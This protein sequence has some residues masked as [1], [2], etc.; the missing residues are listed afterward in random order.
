MRFLLAGSLWTLL[1]PT[2]IYG[3]LTITELRTENL[4]DPIGLDVIKPR[5]SWQLE[6]DRRGVMQVA[7]QLEVRLDGES[8]WNSGKILS[9]QSVFVPYDGPELTSNTTYHWKV[10]IWDQDEKESGWS[11]EAIFQMGIL[12]E[13]VW[14]AR[15]IE[16]TVPEPASRPAQMFRKDFVTEK[17]VTRASLYISSHGVY[18]AYLN[19]A[20][21]GDAYLTPGWTSYNKRIQ[22][23]VYDVTSMVGRGN[24]T[25]GA[26]VGNGWFRGNLAWGGHHNI[27]GKTL[28]LFAQLMITYTDGSTEIIATDA[29]WKSDFSAIRYTEIYHGETIDARKYQ[30]GWN[31]PG[32]DDSSWHPVKVTRDP[33]D[34]LIAT[35]NEPVRKQETFS[36][37]KL[38]TSPKGEKILDFGQNLVGWV[39]V[40]AAGAP[41]DR[42]VLSH[43]EVL[44][45]EGNFYTLS[46]RA[47]KQQNTYILSGTGE[48]TFE[49]HFTW[50]GFRYVRIDE[51]PGEIN[52]L[53][54][55]AVALYSDMPHTGEFTTSNELINQL[56][57]NIQWGQRGN[58]LDVPTDCPQRDERLGWTGD[59]QAF[60]RTAT[61]NFD[62]HNFFAKW[63]K[64]VAAD[65]AADGKVPFVVPDVL[66]PT[67][68]G[69][70][71][72]ADVA[73]IVPWNMYLVYGDKKILSDQYRSMKD[74]IRYMLNNS[75]DFLW[76]KGFHFGDWLFYRPFDDNDGRSA[77]TDKY[78]I[79]QCFFAHSTQ[80][81]INAAKV[82]GQEKDIELY[83]ALLKNV[84]DAF[85]KEYVTPNG[86]LVS[87]TQTAYVLALNFDM[88]PE[89]LRQQAAERLAANVRSYDT[90]LT[91]GFLGTPYLCHVLSR[92]GYGD[93]AYDLLLQKTYPSWLYP[94]TM[95]ATTIWERWD[96]IKPDSTFQTPGMNSFNHYAYGAIGDWMY[97]VMVGLD[98]EE[99]MVGYKHI[100]IKPQIGG[101]FTHANLKYESL[102]G[103][104]AA[105]WKLLGGTLEVEASIPA[106]TT[107][108]F[109]LP[110]E[111]QAILERGEVAKMSQD[112]KYIE[113]SPDGFAVFEAGSGAYHFTMPW[114]KDGM[115]GDLDQYTGTYKT[116]D[117]VELKIKKSGNKLA[118][119]FDGNAIVLERQENKNL[120]TS[121]E[122]KAE[123]VQDQNGKVHEIILEY[124]F[125]TT[126]AIKR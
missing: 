96:G 26:E 114:K 29:T 95:G 56:Q 49:P 123:F 53:D 62:V 60:S 113:Q 112:L 115:Y 39:I 47:A 51:Y 10:K 91:T 28:G 83:T 61:F 68:G 79:A 101:D 110:A 21:V 23:Q 103:E 69:S 43:S 64:D 77:V 99:N 121:G 45:K 42:V 20:R 52:P 76:N 19:G 90:H 24:N 4:K 98:N 74:W 63:L 75:D 18:E 14:K 35:Y 50:Q 81:V 125:L 118:I 102:Y 82:L 12:N 71:G 30:D 55:T 70:A 33:L 44:D 7:Y 93:L 84:K 86:R 15:W 37:V 34:D 104:I 3:Q 87:S 66:G 107:V 80:L 94:V 1:I 106:N 119:D 11:Q 65:Q 122:T 31:Q 17:R 58:F 2:W 126:R 78:L 97:R 48:E 72:W 38:L 111:S 9:D 40:K 124:R 67:S 13:R 100:R 16:V 46:L 41:G 105:G 32:F 92:F 73:T 120:F 117:G 108:K 57:Q 22:Y 54:F 27:Y 85:L 36:V 8:I 89:V 59:A 5:F 25:L 116:E 88:L 109:Y 6:S